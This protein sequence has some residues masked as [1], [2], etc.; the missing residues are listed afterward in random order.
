MNGDWSKTVVNSG[1]PRTLSCSFGRASCTAFATSTVFASGVFVT[2]R[3]SDSLPLVREM[4]STG[5]GTCLISATSDSLRGPS[6][7]VTCRSRIWSRFVMR[8]PTSTGASP[9]SPSISPAEAATPLACRTPAISSTL[10]PLSLTF[11]WSTVMLTCLMSAPD[12]AAARTPASFFS[13]GTTTELR[14][15]ASFSLSPSEATEMTTTG[16]S[17]RAPLNTTG[18][19]PSGSCSL[20][21]AIAP[22]SSRTMSSDEVP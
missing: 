3:V 7:P 5:A 12:T 8:T 4:L 1:V 6:L 10:T 22:S 14:S 15:S 21:L 11:S 16:N 17:S 19:T 18:S 13:S 20:T 2:A 9:L